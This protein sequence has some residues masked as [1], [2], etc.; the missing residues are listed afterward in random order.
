MTNES[1]KTADPS[2]LKT[3][4]PSDWSHVR[5]LLARNWKKDLQKPSLWA[6]K[7]L[8]GPALW[9]MYSI[10]F[11]LGSIDTGDE[12]AINVGEF[13]LYGGENW[14]F[15][16]SLWLGGV[17]ST[18]VES[19]GASI[20]TLFSTITVNDT[21]A[22]ANNATAFADACG[23][24]GG[25]PDEAS[26]GVCVYLEANNTYTIYYGG[27]EMATPFQAALSGAQYAVTTAILN[28]SNAAQ[29]FPVTTVQQVP[30]LLNDSTV[31]VPAALIIVPGILFVLS[32]TIA[33]QFLI[34]PIVYEKIN[35]VA[36]G[37]FMVGVKMRTYLLQWNLYYDLNCLLSASIFTVVTIYWKFAQLSSWVLIF[38]NHYLFFIHMNAFFIL[39]M[40]TQIQEEAAQGKPWL[41]GMFSMAVGSVLLAL[42]SATSIGLYVLGVFVPYLPPMQYFAIYT[43]Y[44][45]AGFDTGIHIGDNVTSSGL[46]GV[47]ITQIVGIVLVFAATLLYSSGE[48]HNWLTHRS[49]HDED[50][51]PVTSNSQNGQDRNRFERLTPGSDVLLTVRNMSHTYMPPRFQP[52][53]KSKPPVEVLK[54]LDMDIC[55]GEVFGFLGH[56]GAGKSTSI[57]I[58]TGQI[59]LQHGQATYHFKDGDEDLS[60]AKDAR[61]I[62]NRIGVCPQHN[63][64]LLGDL[65]GRENLSL[66]AY[67]KGGVDMEPGQSIA[68][69][70]EAEV[71]KRLN[72]IRFTTEGD[73]DKPIDTYSG[74][75]KRKVLIAMALIGSPSVVFL[76]EPTAGLVC[77]TLIFPCR[78]ICCTL[79][80]HLFHLLF[81]HF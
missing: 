14:T 49:H 45:Y 70:V 72:E 5:T 38:F 39:F 31:N 57:S 63:T 44:D 48:F 19:V 6:A 47:F 36:E 15:P 80:S 34:G 7:F 68:E 4:H 29:S 65:S 76:D 74:G 10:G 73:G 30:R 78:F 17:N 46:L 43:T 3:P 35:K 37:F 16:S 81:L 69:A 1:G 61:V 62:R 60:R 18:Y 24:N 28:V 25:I 23:G 9:M 2:N 64:S 67:L 55:R 71:Q 66:I 20:Q 40:Q 32:V 53:R 79:D 33:T 11:F 41:F 13:R 8:L 51:A 42:T 12:N 52:C 26:G 58:L 54:G 77:S 21:T 22:F 27:Q 75:M 50:A 56:N 59:Q